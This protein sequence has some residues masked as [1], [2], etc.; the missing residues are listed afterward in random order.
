[1]VRIKVGGKVPRSN[2]SLTK[3]RTIQFC[4]LIVQILIKLKACLSKLTPRL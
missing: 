3:L 2:I 1:M 4:Q